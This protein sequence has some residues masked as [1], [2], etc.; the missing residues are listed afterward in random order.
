MSRIA[1]VVIAYNRLNSLKRLIGSLLAVDYLGDSVDLII[2][3][4]NSGSEEVANYAHTVEWPHGERVVILHPVRLG[5]KEHVLKCGDLTDL[6]ENICVFEDDI[7]AS[8]GFYSYAKIVIDHFKS[9]DEIAGF[10][11]YTY[12]WNQY[13]D[14]PFAPIQDCYDVFLMQVASSWGQIWTRSRWRGFRQW[15]EN[16]SDE[17]LHCDEMPRSVSNWSSKSW[18]KFHNRYLIDTGKYFL[19][20]KWGLATNFSDQGEH[21]LAST[22]YQVSLLLDVR[23]S[24]SLPKKT[25]TLKKYDAFF[26]NSELADF[27]GMNKG[28]L[29]V[30]LYGDR[31]LRK[32]YLL[33]TNVLNFFVVRRFG[34]AV[35]PMDSNVLL[36][37]PGDGIYLY[38]TTQ[39]LKNLDREILRSINR[40]LYETRSQ[41]KDR[42]LLAAFYFYSVA[43]VRRINSIYSKIKVALGCS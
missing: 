10:S 30:S 25:S 11:L 41:S 37:I 20:P 23:T 1:I 17:Y 32:R 24:Y 3:V 35:R 6:H 28:D 31:P 36:N 4:D 9:A 7:Y 15:L 5:L 40:F 43:I 21:A 16:K 26:E 13:V 14:R 39:K 33:T 38:D 12:E 27:L 18:L 29:D 8:P 2:S 34:I 22:T 42:F 19:Y